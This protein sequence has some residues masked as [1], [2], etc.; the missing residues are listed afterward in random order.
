MKACGNC[1]NWHPEWANGD[2]GGFSYCEWWHKDT[3]HDDGC[4]WHEDKAGKAPAQCG[5][6]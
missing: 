4:E 3:R 2:Y 1:A 5:S 6:Y